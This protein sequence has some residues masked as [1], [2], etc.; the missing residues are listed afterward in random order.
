M[1][2]GWVDLVALRKV[3]NA[4]KIF[5]ARETTENM[6]ANITVVLQFI[7]STFLNGQDSQSTLLLS[8]IVVLFLRLTF[9]Y[10][11]ALQF[12]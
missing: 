12:A 4:N 1:Y 5:S 7:F 6:G 10:S 2:T 8:D 9:M 3:L 11:F